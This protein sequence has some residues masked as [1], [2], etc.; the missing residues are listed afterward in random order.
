M[1]NPLPTFGDARALWNNFYERLKEE[2]N[3]RSY[4]KDATNKAKEFLEDAYIAAYFF[5][6]WLSFGKAEIPCC[7]FERLEAYGLVIGGMAENKTI[8]VKKIGVGFKN[9]IGDYL[10][11]LENPKDNEEKKIVLEL[12]EKVSKVAGKEGIY[13]RFPKPLQKALLQKAE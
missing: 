8:E 13:W 9:E 6:R 3:G 1:E 2:T 10:D 4:R 12:F 7:F 11:F 5:K